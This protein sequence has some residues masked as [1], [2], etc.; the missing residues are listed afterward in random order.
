MSPHASDFGGDTTSPIT[1]PPATPLNA[2]E[3]EQQQSDTN[4]P[5]P[6]QHVLRRRTISSFRLPREEREKEKDKEKE[7]AV[8]T[9]EEEKEKEVYI[10]FNTNFFIFTL[11][12]SKP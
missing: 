4:R 9:I 7:T 2:Q 11:A 6:L 3:V 12:R 8:P 10:N 1:S 5:S